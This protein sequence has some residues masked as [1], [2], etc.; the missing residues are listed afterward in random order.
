MIKLSLKLIFLLLIFNTNSIHAEP[1]Q[2]NMSNLTDELQKLVTK[3]KKEKGIVGLGALVMQNGEVK[4]QA[5]AGVRKHKST[6][7]VTVTVT[8][9][10]QWHLGSITKSITATMLASLVKEGKLSWNSS[11]ADYFDV[12]DFD[13]S[14]KQVT[15]HHLVTHT[16]GVKPNFAMS[17]QFKPYLPEGKERSQARK[18]AVIEV[19][20]KPTKTGSF[21]YSNVGYTI[22]AV[23][24]EQVTGK[25][26][27]ALVRE[28]VFEP[29]K[30]TSAGFGN[31]NFN[32]DQL[33]QPRGHSR[34]FGIR[35]AADQ[36]DDNTPIMAP[37]GAT[38]M[39]LQDLAFYA[40][41]H[42]QGEQGKGQLFD[43]TVYQTLHTSEKEDYAYGW[44]VYEQ[45]DWANGKLVWHNGSNTM[46]YAIV[47]M[48]PEKNAVMT[49]A[50]N[51]GR[52]DVLEESAIKLFKEISN[53]I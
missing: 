10:D 31:P 47:V 27:A 49:F 52:V 1:A 30:L 46:W 41:E 7:P 11:V 12:N 25:T 2:T 34:I 38:H 6:V 43:K 18:E 3:I 53:Q 16:S 4:A 33:T 22:A 39:S 37:A 42:L 32:G 48:L 44:V 14:W 36:L 50:A 9:N 29:L 19:L 23:I 26:W 40:N 20:K 13:P 5:V 8:V 24:A 51:E 45:R 28:K 15:L 35:S 21:S 17:Y